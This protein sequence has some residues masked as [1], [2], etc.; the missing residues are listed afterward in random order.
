MTTTPA[1]QYRD[2]QVDVK[3]VLSALWIAVLFVFAY[4]DVFAFFRADVLEA[5]LDGKV[6][7]T[8]FSVDQAFLTLALVYVLVPILMVVLSLVLPARGNRIANFVVSLLYAITVLASCIGETWVYYIAGSVVEAILLLAIAR[9][10]W[11]WS[12]S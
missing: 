2:T 5:A 9:L 8:R 1:H 7:S 3:L 12:A 4:V 6:A 11:K 10:A